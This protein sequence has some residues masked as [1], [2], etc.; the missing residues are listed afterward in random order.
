M[1]GPT[2]LNNPECMN[3][4]SSDCLNS[5]LFMK[6]AQGVAGG[7]TGDKGVGAGKGSG[8]GAGSRAPPGAFPPSQGAQGS[9]GFMGGMAMM[10]AG[11]DVNPMM[12]PLFSQYPELMMYPDCM[13][14]DASDCMAKI[15]PNVIKQ[16][17]G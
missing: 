14:A 15:L 1:S 13:E 11:S 9:S 4:D 16:H 3:G 6:M 7:L 10:G 17:K 5:M 12:L 8:A 2:Y